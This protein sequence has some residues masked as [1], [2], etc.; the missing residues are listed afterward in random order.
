[1]KKNNLILIAFAVLALAIVLIVVSR[2]PPAPKPEP[3][4]TAVAPEITPAAGGV[5]REASKAAGAQPGTAPGKA[6]APQTA[7]AIQSPSAPRLG[8]AAGAV[9]PGV[10]APKERKF[11]GEDQLRDAIFGLD[12]DKREEALTELAGM[13]TEGQGQQVLKEM[14][15]SDKK[16]LQEEALILIPNLDEQ[17]RMPYIMTGL[18]NADPEFRLESLSQLRDLAE[19]DPSPAMTKALN[20][21]DPNVLE[22]LSDLFFYFSDKPI[23]D[24]ATLGLKHKNEDIR[25]EALSYLEDTHTPRSVELLIDALTSEHKEI[26]EGAGDALRFMTNAEIENNDR[27]AW[28]AWW[29]A[30]K[31]RWSSEE[32]SAE[33]G[34]E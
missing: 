26:A 1:M 4:T 5:A 10:K 23:Y 30:N 7:T 32:A 31:D 2:R 28:L 20:D 15:E 25:R 9:A 6:A 13:L 3:A 8:A 27:D 24:V 16:D 14:F 19:V 18:D 12:P 34:S 22:E 17:Y 21:Q 29:K 33:P 11:A